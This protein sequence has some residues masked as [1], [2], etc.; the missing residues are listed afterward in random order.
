MTRLKLI[1]PAFICIIAGTPVAAQPATVTQAI[2]HTTTNII[3]PE[4]EDASA[5]NPQGQGGM[6]FRNFGDG[7]TKSVTYL[8]G[9]LVKTV[10]KS[11]TFRSTI[12]RNNDTRTTTTI[13][14]I[15][16]DKRGF[17]ITDEEQA[18]MM[19][20]RDSMM[21]ARRRNDSSQ[22]DAAISINNNDQ[23]IEIIPTEE[24]KKI[25]GYVCTKAWMVTTRLLGIKDSVVL[26]YTPE[27]KIQNLF[28]TGGTSGFGNMVNPVGRGFEKVDGFVMGYEMNMR[29]NRKMEVYV[30][31]IELNKEIAD[32]EFDLP[33]DIDIKPMKEMQSMFGGGQG[34]FQFRRTP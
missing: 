12:Y 22:R 26:W 17:Y 30:T 10:L 23:P 16:G 24:K 34:N 6:S 1:L 28:S 8:K 7:E 18:A 33:K 5:I 11:E 29:R 3:A 15:M 31:K 14:E 32:K 25:A 19:K 27:L 13:F 20:Q 2:V 9:G 4:D 21:Q